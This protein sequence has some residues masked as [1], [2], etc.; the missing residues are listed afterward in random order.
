ML[1]I[2]NFT[3][4]VIILFEKFEKLF[5]LHYLFQTK[6]SNIAK[7]AALKLTPS[8]QTAANASLLESTTNPVFPPLYSLMILTSA[9]LMLSSALLLI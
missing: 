8:D 9:S 1:N 7:C 2:F 5:Y 3:Y 4:T 6:L